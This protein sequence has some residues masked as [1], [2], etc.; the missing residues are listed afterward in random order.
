M[1]VSC[2]QKDK[3]TARY[4]PSRPGK[5]LVAVV[6]YATFPLPLKL[7]IWAFVVVAARFLYHS[8]SCASMVNPSNESKTKVDLEPPDTSTQSES[9]TCIGVRGC[10]C[11]TLHV[12]QPAIRIVYWSIPNQPTNFWPSKFRTQLPHFA[13]IREVAFHPQTTSRYPSVSHYK[14][15]T[16]ST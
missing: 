16:F 12:E 2:T 3:P 4:Q 10:Y 14:D 1:K 7:L 8:L 15:S 11:P 9:E 13:M 6:K 5:R